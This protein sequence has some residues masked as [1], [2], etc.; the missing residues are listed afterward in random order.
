LH[1]YAIFGNAGVTNMP[2]YIGIQAE[3][4]RQGME[5]VVLTE[6]VLIL[7]TASDV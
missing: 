5:T 1:V 7:S 2:K 6:A 3:G 4:N